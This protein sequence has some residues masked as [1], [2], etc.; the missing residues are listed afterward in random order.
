MRIFLNCSRELPWET[1]ISH[2]KHMM[3]RLQY[4]GYDQRFRTEVVRSALKAYNHLVELD[5]R[6]EQPLYR[7]RD[8][9]QNGLKRDGGSQKPGTEKVVSTL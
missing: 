2:V 8:W 7:P 1:V 5:V 9:R 4:S 3:L 6:D